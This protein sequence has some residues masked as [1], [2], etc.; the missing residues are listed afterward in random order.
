M[1]ILEEYVICK[2]VPVEIGGPYLAWDRFPT[3]EAATAAFKEIYSP[4]G[5]DRFIV[6]RVTYEEIDVQRAK[7]G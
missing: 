3:L 5:G 7:P 4:A 1:A 2:R 6:T